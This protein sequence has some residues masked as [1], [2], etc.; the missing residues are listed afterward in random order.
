MVRVSGMIK[1]YGTGISVRFVM[2][3]IPGIVFIVSGATEKPM[4]KENR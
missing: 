4:T 2:R 1:E 3:V